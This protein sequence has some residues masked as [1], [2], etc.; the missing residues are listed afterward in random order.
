MARVGLV[1][2]WGVALEER[3]PVARQRVDALLA[4]LANPQ[5]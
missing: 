3:L 1:S 4:A 5:P 2:G